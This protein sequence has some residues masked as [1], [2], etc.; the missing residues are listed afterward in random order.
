M[1]ENSQLMCGCGHVNFRSPVS[2]TA[3]TVW[4]SVFHIEGVWTSLSSIAATASQLPSVPHTWGVEGKCS[5]GF[6]F[7][8][9]YMCSLNQQVS[10]FI[11]N[12][13]LYLLTCSHFHLPE[14]QKSV[15]WRPFHWVKLSLYKFIT[16]LHWLYSTEYLTC[17]VN[18]TKLECNECW[19]QIENAYLGYVPTD[20]K[21][22]GWN[23]IYLMV[24]GKRWL[25]CLICCS[26]QTLIEGFKVSELWS[27]RTF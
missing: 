12:P 17:Q 15:L 13:L 19:D 11:L 20:L 23:V 26:I 2:S 18:F 14:F 3:A 16:V 9:A 21:K 5:T 1:R 7:N 6:G 24:R 27:V 22:K 25:K 8:G 4:Q 10:S